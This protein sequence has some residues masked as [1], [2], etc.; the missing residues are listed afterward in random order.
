MDSDE[1]HEEDGEDDEDEAGDG[2]G[3][4]FLALIEFVGNAGRSGDDEDAIENEEEG[5]TAPEADDDAEEASDKAAAFSVEGDTAKSGI[6]AFA[7]ITIGT[8]SK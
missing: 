2:R 4:D 3:D 8:S 5:D 6:D 7:A 1:L